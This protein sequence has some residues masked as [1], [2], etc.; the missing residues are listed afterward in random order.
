M[1]SAQAYVAKKYVI[2][3]SEKLAND[4]INVQFRNAEDL[5]KAETFLSK[6]N[7]DL[8]FVSNEAVT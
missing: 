4:S 6:Q 3:F 5:E 2:A 1:I 8:L 7:R